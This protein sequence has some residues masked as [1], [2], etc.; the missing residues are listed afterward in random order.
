LF[1]RM[2]AEGERTLGVAH[3][4][5]LTTM[6]NLAIAYGDAGR[7]ADAVPLLEQVVAGLERSLGPQHPHTVVAGRSLA[8]AR[9]ELGRPVDRPDAR[10]LAAPASDGS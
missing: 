4:T 1:E 7:V 10:G 2:L 9:E 3:P 8:S 5:T 6:N